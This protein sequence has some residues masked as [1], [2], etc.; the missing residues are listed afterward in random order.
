MG[1]QGYKSK[2]HSYHTKEIIVALIYKINP[3]QITTMTTENTENSLN[4]VPHTIENI[5]FKN[6]EKFS[7]IVKQNLALVS[8]VTPIYL[9]ALML[10]IKRQQLTGHKIYCEGK[11]TKVL[12]THIFLTCTFRFPG[13][14]NA[15][16]SISQINI[17]QIHQI[18]M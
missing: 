14:T 1:L 18:K 3:V 17:N 2:Y 8:G 13:V 11:R 9:I 16:G 6:C 7:L 4:S 5:H 10:S 12:Q 15:I